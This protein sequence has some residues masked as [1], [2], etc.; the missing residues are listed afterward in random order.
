MDL[1]VLSGKTLLSIGTKE[2]SE[3]KS[4]GATL[5]A[6]LR[7]PQHR[8]LLPCREGWGHH[9]GHLSATN[10]AAAPGSSFPVEVKQVPAPQ[11]APAAQ[12]KVPPPQGP[13]WCHHAQVRFLTQEGPSAISG[14]EFNQL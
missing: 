10:H 3:Q 8:M 1:G 14:R 7:P 13:L 2:M 11:A 5:T 9:W 4:Q 12:G 6:K